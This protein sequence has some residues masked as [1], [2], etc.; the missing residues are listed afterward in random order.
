MTDIFYRFKLACRLSNP[1]ILVFWIKDFDVDPALEFVGWYFYDCSSH[2]IYTIFVCYPR[3]NTGGIESGSVWIQWD[4]P[5][6]I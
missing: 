5:I 2:Y 4:H 3:G 6:E 1:F